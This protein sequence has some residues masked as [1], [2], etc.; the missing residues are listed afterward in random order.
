MIFNLNMSHWYNY[1]LCVAM[2]AGGVL[3]LVKSSDLFVD[4]ASFFAKKLKIPTLVIGLTVVAF[5]T[6]LPELAVS[7]SDSVA[8][9]VNGGNAN[10]AIGNVV[11]SNIC[12]ILLVLGCSIIISPIILK[13]DIV[14]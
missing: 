3:L 2:I 13:K 6:S 4:S 5:G 12:N 8:C 11:G 9:L 14:F 1:L 7:S 10:I